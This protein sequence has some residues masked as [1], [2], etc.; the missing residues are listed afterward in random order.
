MEKE[1]SSI[2]IAHMKG[3]LLGSINMDK[4]NND[5]STGINTM[6]SISTESRMGKENIIGKM[7]HFTKALSKMD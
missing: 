6:E 3:N 1:Y 2:K 5:L 7:A 4:E